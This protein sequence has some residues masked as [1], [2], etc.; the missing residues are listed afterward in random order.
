MIAS[1][2]LGLYCLHASKV[3]KYIILLGP[4]TAADNI[5]SCLI[6]GWHLKCF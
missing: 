4:K 3:S 1:S 5:F 2:D 6:F